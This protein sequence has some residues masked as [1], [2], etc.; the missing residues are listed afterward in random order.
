M[1][2]IFTVI[3]GGPGTDGSAFERE[4][5]VAV[6]GEAERE[7]PALSVAADLWTFIVTY[8]EEILL[9]LTLADSALQI[10]DRLIELATRRGA[11]IKVVDRGREV[12]VETGRRQE[13]ADLVRAVLERSAPAGG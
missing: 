12:T 8:K 11:T 3:A 10:V 9:G 6:A 7:G 2:A 1:D 4:L 5:A 13:A